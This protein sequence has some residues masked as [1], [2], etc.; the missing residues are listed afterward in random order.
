MHKIELGNKGILGVQT[1]DSKDRENLISLSQRSFRSDHASPDAKTSPWSILAD[2]CTDEATV[3]ASFG[4]VFDSF[5][6]TPKHLH[7]LV[8]TKL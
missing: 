8:C 6:G 4:Q 1:S 7:R 5:I 3:Q 2:G